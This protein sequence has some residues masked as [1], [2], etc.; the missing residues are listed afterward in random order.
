MKFELRKC[1]T[2]QAMDDH[3]LIVFTRLIS[4]N[5]V[6]ETATVSQRP[7]HSTGN[8]ASGMRQLAGT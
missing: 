8:P 2:Q 7:I 5:S 1:L 3:D 4:M 6:K